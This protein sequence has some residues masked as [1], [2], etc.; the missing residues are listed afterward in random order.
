M[1]VVAG[2][3]G[4]AD[5]RGL[6]SQ[7]LHLFPWRA[8]A[9]GFRASS[10]QADGRGRGLGR[11]SRE[12]PVAPPDAT[13]TLACGA[14]AWACRVAG[15]KVVADAEPGTSRSARPVA[16]MSALLF[17]N[18]MNFPGSDAEWIGRAPAWGA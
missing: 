16:R 2:D 11:I 1:L 5:Y 7:V 14:A 10:G 6:C 17:R 4:L 18:L 15:A 13:V 8:V 9:G 3:V 12:E